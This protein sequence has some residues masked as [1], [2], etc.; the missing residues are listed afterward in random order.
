MPR[1]RISISIPW[2]PRNRDVVAARARMADDAGV[3]TIWVNE[4]FGHD[5]FSGLTVLALETQNARLGTSI[6]NVYSRTAG[7]LAQHFATLDQLSDG[8]IVA[9]LGTS[10][11]GV[12]ERFHGVPYRPAIARLEETITLLRAFWRHERPTL[13]GTWYDI[14]RAL[15]MGV[16]PVQ[17]DLP[18]HLATLY[19]RSVRLTAQ[20]ADGWLPAW[21][22]F[23][24][25]PSAIAQLRAWTVEAARREDAVE[26]RA[27][28][29]VTV[30]ADPVRAE[31][32]RQAR[33]QQLAFFVARNG[34]FYYRQFVRHGLA[35]EAASIRHAWTTG[36]AEA[37]VAA[38]PGGLEDRF[39]FVGPLEA[40]VEH[41]DAQMEAGVD[42]HQVSLPAG[43]ES[44]WTVAAL[45]RL[46]G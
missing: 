13:H 16:D 1:R 31:E 36:G 17:P 34:D 37:G 5:A 21:I 38:V 44:D 45:R 4:G 30:I 28:G 41:L 15:V 20:Q 42:L 2:D 8:R 39:D 46:A 11:V 6:V 12:I 3:D 40:C 35:D 24:R 29:M 18:I 43:S 23:D 25:L 9:G 33:R 10:G 19:P 22:P 27:P 7:A 26:V 32:A 14:E